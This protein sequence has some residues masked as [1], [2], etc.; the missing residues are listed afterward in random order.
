LTGGEK[1]VEGFVKVKKE[2]ANQEIR[3]F[4]W[5]KRDANQKYV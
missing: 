2:K 5:I 3:S 4:I 1:D